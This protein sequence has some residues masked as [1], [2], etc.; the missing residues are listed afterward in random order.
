MMAKR[1]DIQVGIF[2]GIKD[3]YTRKYYS[4]KR[5]KKLLFL[6]FCPKYPDK[7]LLHS[8]TTREGCFC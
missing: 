1:E 7:L 4:C 3:L 8:D 6:D 2:Y 5:K